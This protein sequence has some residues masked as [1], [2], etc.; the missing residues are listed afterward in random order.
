MP[1]PKR[2]AKLSTGLGSE[3]PRP[4]E[5]D[6]VAGVA[7]SKDTTLPPTAP[8]RTSVTQTLLAISPSASAMADSRAG[9]KALVCACQVMKGM[10]KAICCPCASA[11]NSARGGGGAGSVM[12]VTLV[13]G[14]PAQT[15]AATGLLPLKSAPTILVRLASDTESFRTATK[16]RAV[17]PALASATA[18]S[19]MSDACSAAPEPRRGARAY[20]KAELYT[21]ELFFHCEKPMSTVMECSEEVDPTDCLQGAVGECVAITACGFCAAYCCRRRPGTRVLSK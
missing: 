16:K 5:E 7:M 3:S 19:T 8:A 18:V 12:R 20:A 9:E 11:L 2:A 6:S 14:R 13:T 4:S 15:K 17:L 1:M 10:S 21:T